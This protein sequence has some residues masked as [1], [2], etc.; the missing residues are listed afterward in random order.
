MEICETSGPPTAWYRVCTKA[1]VPSK[2]SYEYGEL[3]NVIHWLVQRPH[4]PVRGRKLPRSMGGSKGPRMEFCEVSDLPR[5]MVPLLRQSN[6]YI[7]RKLRVCRAQKCNALVGAE[8]PLTCA[9][10]QTT[11]FHGG[12]YRSENGNMRNFGPTNTHGTTFAPKQWLH[13]NEATGM[14]SSKM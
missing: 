10:S 11:P 13:Q 1:M 6:G 8:T 4:L 14:E 2:G 12:E 5:A 3:K 7:K 9:V